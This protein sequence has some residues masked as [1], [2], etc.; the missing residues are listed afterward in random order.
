MPHYICVTCGVQF[1]ETTEPSASCPICEDERQYVGWGGQKWTTL[2]DLARDHHNIIREVEPGLIGIRTEP[3]VGIG[4]RALLV[5][6]PDGNVL[7]DCISLIDAATVAAVEALGGLSSI[8]VSHPHMFG[9]MV[10]WSHAFGDVPIHLHASYRRWTMRPDPAIRY[11]DGDTLALGAGLTLIRCGGHFTGST[12]LHWADGAEGR[13]ALLACDT[14]FVTKDRRHVTFMRSIPNYIP[15][16][17]Q[18]VDSIVT[19][20]DP[21]DY[22]RI[23]SQFD[24]LEILSGGRE[25]VARSAERYKQ[26]IRG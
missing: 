21:Y 25:A 23:Y 6:S 1:A 16:S 2:E 26:A 9:S 13:G 17:A 14:I 10:D 5:Q 19:A 12:V 24:G 11:F 18:T 20:L 3:Q 8:T 4:Q 22:D 15:V 7:W